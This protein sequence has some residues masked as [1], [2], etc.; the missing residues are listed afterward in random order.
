[1]GRIIGLA[2]QIRWYVG[3]V[4]GDSH[5]R[6]YLEHHRRTHPGTPVLSEGEYWRMRH[7]A[8]DVSPSPRC[9]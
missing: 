4:M 5:Y 8:A 3:A 9:C 2:R 7:R 1:M 6:R